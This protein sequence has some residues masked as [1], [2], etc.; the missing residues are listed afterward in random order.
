MAEGKD[1]FG[2]SEM[3]SIDFID[4]ILE[5]KTASHGV[6][7]FMENGPDNIAA[8]TA[9]CPM[10]GKEIGKQAGA[11]G[12]VRQSG[13]LVIDKRDQRV[14]GAPIRLGR[15]VA[16]AVRGFYGWS[17]SLAFNFGLGL[18]HLLHIIQELY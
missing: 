14:S 15:P 16:P 5:Q 9:I 18:A 4:H 11:F 10:Q 3:N 13:F 7:Y 17:E 12:S 2:G 1:F 8:V 6:V